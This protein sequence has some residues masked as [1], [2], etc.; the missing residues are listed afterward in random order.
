MAIVGDP[1]ESLWAPNGIMCYVIRLIGKPVMKNLFPR[2]PRSL[3]IQ[4][5]IIRLIAV[6][7][8]TATSRYDYTIGDDW[9]Y[10]WYSWWDHQNMNKFGFRLYFR[11]MYGDNRF[12]FPLFPYEPDGEKK[13]CIVLRSGKNDSCTPF[14]KDEF[15]RRFFRAMG[16]V[17]L[18]GSFV[19]LYI[20]GV[21]KAYYNPCN[22]D[23]SQFF[24]EWYGTDN[25][26]DVI[27]QSGLRDGDTIAWDAF[28]NY[29]DTHDLSIPDNYDYVASQFDITTVY[30]F[31][32]CSDS[33]WQFRLA[34]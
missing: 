25:E 18:T 7:E 30:R 6:S 22:R 3:I 28:L 13:Q 24:Q 20:N 16:G 27:T 1:T 8:S 29:I 21:Y 15:V 34:Q 26:F 2:S 9:L 19:N 11:S 33:L 5:M 10:C 32:D 12:D 4:A 14:A 23:N 31:P 17:Q